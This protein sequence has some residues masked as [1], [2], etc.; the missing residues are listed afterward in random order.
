MSRATKVA[1][2]LTREQLED[3]LVEAVAAVLAKAPDNLAYNHVIRSLR[4]GELHDWRT[5]GQR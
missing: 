2:P 3:E 4:V 5:A 1:A